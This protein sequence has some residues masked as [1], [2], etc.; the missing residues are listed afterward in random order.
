[1]GPMMEKNIRPEGAKQE[2]EKQGLC[3]ALSGRVFMNNFF[4]RRCPGLG[5]FGLSALDCGNFGGQFAT[6][7]KAPA[8]SSR[9]L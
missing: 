8:K 2:Y 5:C 7:K 9:A 3:D 4:P 1:M 6:A